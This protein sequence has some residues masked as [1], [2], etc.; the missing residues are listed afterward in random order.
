MASVAVEAAPAPVALEE[1]KAF[2][3]IEHSAEDALIAGLVRSAAGAC[4]AF[5]G[6]ALV[7][8]EAAQIL[9]ASAA[10]Q[11]LALGPVRAITGVAA[12][13]DGG[14]ETALAAA[15]YAIDIDAAGDGW[16]RLLRLGEAK[17]A[18]VRFTAGMSAD[19]N[20]VPEPLRHGIVRL[21]AHLYLE[22]GA[23]TAVPPAAV[24][25]L[26]RPWRRLR[27]A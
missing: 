11:R 14:A 9:T 3:R 15:D 10:W 18:R 23:G 16:V 6:L 21:A 20:G 4:E 19:W 27:V 2:L 13:T 17:R 1:V 24:A 25:A 26:W 12:L 7:E 22:R 8:R 5:T